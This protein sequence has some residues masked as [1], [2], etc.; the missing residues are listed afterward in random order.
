MSTTSGPLLSVSVPLDVPSIP[1][2]ILWQVVT[3]I[4]H[5]PDIVETVVSMERL[6]PVL[7]GGRGGDKN[8]NNIRVGT[9]WCE[10]RTFRQRQHEVV[11]IKT[12]VQLQQN[13]YPKSMSLNV[14]VEIRKL[15]AS[16]VQTTITNGVIKH[17]IELSILGKTPRVRFTNT[18]RF[19][20]LEAIFSILN[21]CI[22][23]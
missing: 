10:T 23:C 13:E 15:I 20:I 17:T 5:L 12:V 7:R 4:D 14:S 22:I 21:E 2:E 6:T 3:D 16:V 11:Q 1:A 9:R 19:L 8:N 18:V